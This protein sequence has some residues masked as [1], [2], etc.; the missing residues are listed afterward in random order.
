MK[1]LARRIVDIPVKVQD[2]GGQTV[3]QGQIEYAFQVGNLH[4]RDW[5]NAG[6]GPPVGPELLQILQLFISQ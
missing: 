4:V 1:K 3:H 6:L 5:V 2:Q